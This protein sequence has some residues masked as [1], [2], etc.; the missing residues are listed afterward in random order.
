MLTS[1]TK[2]RINACRD[3]LVGKL[4]QPAQQVELITLGGSDAAGGGT[5]VD[6]RLRGQN[7][8]RPRPRQRN[9]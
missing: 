6:L 8:A 9:G 2:R 3:I 4:P 1:E 7:P 5:R